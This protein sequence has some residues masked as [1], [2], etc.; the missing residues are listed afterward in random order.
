MTKM[1]DPNQKK[2]NDII[3]KYG[4]DPNWIYT[5]QG[6]RLINKTGI[7]KLAIGLGAPVDI[8]LAHISEK[9]VVVKATVTIATVRYTAL[10]EAGPRNCSFPYPV[11]V[12][13]KRARSRVILSALGIHGF[14]YG[15]DEV[16]FAV[17]A[18]KI[19]NERAQA[20]KN[21]TQST[22]DKIKDKKK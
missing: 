15:E 8:Q 12:A 5:K 21:S 7:D 4:I 9:Y 2:V 16:D 10:G 6:V 19:L 20:A 11:A 1:N 17:Q 14:L 13:E 3:V 22:L 18:N